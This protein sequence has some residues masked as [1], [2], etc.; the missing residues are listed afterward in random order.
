LNKN[1]GSADHIKAIK[2]Q[3]LVI[4]EILAQQRYSKAKSNILSEDE[5][6]VA[7]S[8]RL[9]QLIELGAKSAAYKKSK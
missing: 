7:S 8:F 2:M 4:I 6:I 1:V 5:R 3:K 9:V